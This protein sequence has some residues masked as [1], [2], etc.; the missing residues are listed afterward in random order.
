M[1]SNGDLPDFSRFDEKYLRAALLGAEKGLDDDVFTFVA[2]V[3]PMVNVDLLVYDDVGRVLLSW[4]DDGKNLGWHIPGGIIR[5]KETFEERIQK[6]AI[7]ELGTKVEYKKDPVK[8]S[9]IF[10]PYQRRG[11]FISFLY[12]CRL[13][14][15]CEIVNKVNDREEGFLKWHD[16]MPEP[17]VEGQM[18]YFDFLKSIL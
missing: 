1:S 9:E 18:C 2:S 13:P 12:E 5:F 3:T 14:Q 11:H 15:E 7:K 4:R 16:S 17:L 8:I 6:T 10:M